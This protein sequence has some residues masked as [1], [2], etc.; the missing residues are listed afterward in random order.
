MRLSIGIIMENK[1]YIIEELLEIC[2]SAVQVRE[3]NVYSV[4]SSYFTNLSSDILHKIS[5]GKEPVYHFSAEIPFKVPDK[6]FE[7][8]HKSILQKVNPEKNNSEVFEELEQ[9]SPFLNS[10]SKKPVFTVPENY[11]SNVK[12]FANDNLK[13]GAKVIPLKRLSVVMRY[14]VAAVI[15]TLLGVGLFLLTQK[16]PGLKYE[17][18]GSAEIRVKSLSEQDILEYLKTTSFA[19]DVTAASKNEVE[20]RRSV[21]KMSDN[22]IKEFLKEN[23]ETDGI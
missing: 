10:I 4:S 11:F 2:P 5:E 9:I 6:Y 8:L 22:E 17:S 12:S 1:N 14:F 15:T 3:A 23:G 19:D 7:N 13:P 16:S 20:I 18:A 21:S